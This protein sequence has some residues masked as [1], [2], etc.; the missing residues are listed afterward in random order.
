MSPSVNITTRKTKDSGPRYV[1]RYRVGGRAFKQIHGGSFRTMREAR[2]RRDF[3]AGELAA[4]RDPRVALAAMLNVPDVVTAAEWANRW[5]ASL[6]NL[7][8]SSR[9][10]YASAVAWFKANFDGDVHAITP[11]RLQQVVVE[12]PLSARSLKTYM[13]ATKQILDFASVE[14]NPARD[15]RVR[16]PRIE[17]EPLN[18]P[19]LSHVNAIIANVRPRYILPLRILAETGVRV[20]ELVAWTWGDVDVMESRI[21]VPKGKTKSARRWVHIDPS[22][23]ESLLAT[24][25]P[26]D[27]A[28]TRR[29]FH[30]TTGTLRTQVK[31]AC[32]AARIPHYTPHDFRH[33]HISVLLKQGFSRAEVAEIHGHSNT[34]ELATYEHVVL[35]D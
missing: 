13:Q 33:R 21:L 30:V 27:R 1:V 15:R 31:N 4:G 25:P 12:S 29:L 35:E 28:S 32:V 10:T 24:C 20:G 34:N 11:A 26:D 19:P 3:I 5:L 22:L 18:P 17:K 14:P 16:L 6:V 8:D 2:T 23:M 9:V 7:T